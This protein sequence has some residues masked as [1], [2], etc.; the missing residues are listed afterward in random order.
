[1]SVIGLSI[2]NAR[3]SCYQALFCGS[4]PNDI[5]IV[6]KI[7]SYCATV[8]F[9]PFYGNGRLFSVKIPTVFQIGKINKWTCIIPWRKDPMTFI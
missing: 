5:E 2:N 4:I 6:L 1:M 7:A 9:W 3:A 8:Y